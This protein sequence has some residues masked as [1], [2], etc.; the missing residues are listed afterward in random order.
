MG[1]YTIQEMLVH[2][3]LISVTGCWSLVRNNAAGNMWSAAECPRYTEHRIRSHSLTFTPDC[4]LPVS[5]ACLLFPWPLSRVEP[6]VV[7][8][9]PINQFL[10]WSVC[11]VFVLGLQRTSCQIKF[12]FPPLF[13]GGTEYRNPCFRITIG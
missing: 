12:H 1:R 2:N 13:Y 6:G 8:S 4:Q 9:G 7:I 11:N 3:Y 10:Y 5:S